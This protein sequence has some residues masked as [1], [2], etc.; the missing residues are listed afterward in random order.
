MKIGGMGEE[1]LRIPLA[2]M[3]LLGELPADVEVVR[4]LPPPRALSGMEYGTDWIA[5]DKSFPDLFLHIRH[6]FCV[7]APPGTQLC[8]GYL[9]HFLERYND[10]KRQ[11]DMW[12]SEKIADHFPEGCASHWVDN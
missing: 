7:R 1:A 9:Q 4:V 6:R 8:Y 2:D 3:R 10:L 5:G 11:E 12:R